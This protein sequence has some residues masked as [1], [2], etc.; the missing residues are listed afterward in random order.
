[1]IKTILSL[2][3]LLPPSTTYTELITF[4]MCD[5]LADILME[6]VAEETINQHESEEIYQRCLKTLDT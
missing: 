2:L 6:A 1:M 4:S 3:L 5:E